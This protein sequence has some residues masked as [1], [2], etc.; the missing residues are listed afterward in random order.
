MKRIGIFGGSFNP[1][2][3][4][5][6]GLA[7]AL[8]LQN[9]VDEVWLL[10]SPQN[11]LKQRAELAD[12]QIRFRLAGLAVAE[13]PGV[14]ASDFEFNLPR[15]SYTFRT[16][17]ALE[18]VCPEAKFSL[19]MGGDNWNIFPHWKKYEQLLERYAII[20]YPRPGFIV[21]TSNMPQN[22]R[23]FEAPLYPWSST[24]VRNRI[25]SGLPVDHMLPSAV[26]HEINRL[27]LYQ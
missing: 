19:I 10:V 12:E 5:H 21:D 6:V 24:D 4:G 27:H 8:V 17:E 1:V 18:A 20:V 16:M 9:W 22:V 15:P 25:H 7:R 13:I 14:E 26:A 11:P 2:H 23:L 3:N